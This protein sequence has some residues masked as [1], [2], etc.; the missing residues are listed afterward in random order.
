MAETQARIAV[1]GG[2]GLYD[3]PMDNAREAAVSTPYGE[4][5]SPIVIGEWRG[6]RSRFWRV[7]GRGTGSCL[8]RFRRGRT[9]TR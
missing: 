1:I 4:P 9:F 8:R 5:G 7:T 6:R 3:M 2:T